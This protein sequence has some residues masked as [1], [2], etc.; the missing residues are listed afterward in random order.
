[1]TSLG[2]SGLISVRKVRVIYL[3]LELEKKE[4]YWRIVCKEEANFFNATSVYFGVYKASKNPSSSNE[5]LGKKVYKKNEA[6]EFV[7]DSRS[8]WAVIQVTCPDRFPNTVILIKYKVTSNDLSF[9]ENT[10][11]RAD[12][13]PG[14]GFAEEKIHFV[15]WG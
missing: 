2:R 13:K 4:N 12:A 10:M 14:R 9:V 5:V 8:Y 1:M 7:G 11:V 6:I 15:V 3:L